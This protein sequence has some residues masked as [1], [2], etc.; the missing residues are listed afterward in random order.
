MCKN[1]V[2]LKIT[3]LKCVKDIKGGQEILIAQRFLVPKMWT[4]MKSRN[5]V[6]FMLKLIYHFNVT[7][8]V[9]DFMFE[10]KERKQI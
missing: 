2:A 10:K 6:L 5:P 4:N 9:V 1:K 3:R 7:F 8:N